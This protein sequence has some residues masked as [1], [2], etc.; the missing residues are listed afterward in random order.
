VAAVTLLAIGDILIERPDP[1]TMFRHSRSLFHS[2]D[3]VFANCEQ[4]C[5][6]KGVANPFL[7]THATPKIAEAIAD[8]GIS[9]VSLAN[10]HTLDWGE[11]GILDTIERLNTLGISTLGAGK[12][13]LAARKPIVVAKSGIRF[14]FLAYGCIGPEGYEATATKAGH[15]PMRAWTLYEKAYYQPATPPLIRSFADREDLRAMVDDIRQLRPECDILSVSYHWGLHFAP[16]VIPDYCIEVGQA[17][18]DAGADIV[19]G[20]HPHILKGIEF[21]KG[22]PIFYSMENFAVELGL[23]KDP[24]E[25]IHPLMTRLTKLYNFTPVSRYYPF[26]AESLATIIVKIV[27]KDNR[28]ERVSYLPCYINENRE[29]EVVTRD[30]PRG[31]QVFEYVQSITRSESLRAEFCWNEDG[32]EVIIN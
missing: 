5:S 30:H 18:V 8:A 32:T 10:N 14:G 26:H 22:K 9:L 15:A 25:E 29:P 20:H 23:D 4:M 17:A 19:L 13:I 2:G 24:D 21:Y 12:D 3:I 11:E 27:V 6:D 16:R 31:V 7:A 1:T 28:L